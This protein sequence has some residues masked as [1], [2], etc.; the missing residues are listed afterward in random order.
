MLHGVRT[1]VL[2]NKH[3]QI[4]DTHSVSAGLDYPGVGPELSSWKDSA[5][6]HFVSATDAEA[7]KGFRMLSQSEG[8]IPAL[9]SS[10]AIWGAVE[11][12]RKYGD[13]TP[14]GERKRDIVICLSGRGDKDV[15]SVADELPVLGPEIG[16]DLRF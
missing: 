2:Q 12:A 13:E 10:H 5:R 8:I 11:L 7:L 4:S 3:G 9:E 15:Q 6:A 1:Y 16:W 14:A